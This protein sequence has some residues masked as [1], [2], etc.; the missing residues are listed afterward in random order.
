MNRWLTMIVCLVVSACGGGPGSVDTTPLGM[1]PATTD[2]GSAEAEATMTAEASAPEA[3]T[4]DPTEAAA[5]ETGAPGEDAGAG[6][7]SQLSPPTFDPP[8]GVIAAGSTIRIAC[9]MLPPTGVIL[10]TLDGN[11]PNTSTHQYAGPIQIDTDTIARATCSDP[12]DGFANS[13]VATAIY[14][15]HPAPAPD[16]GAPTDA[17]ATIDAAP[18]LVWQQYQ[19]WYYIAQNPSPTYYNPQNDT[20]LYGDWEP[21]TVAATAPGMSGC[22]TTSRLNTSLP[23]GSNTPVCPTVNTADQACCILASQPHPGETAIPGEWAL[24]CFC[25]VHSAGGPAGVWT[26]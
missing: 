24:T 4:A 21:S 23:V 20:W 26:F 16:A 11:D 7:L 5:P 15:I 17:G 8:S 9:P 3:G 10:F 19:S 25:N 22:I 2:A 6:S 12:T 18:A 13:Q 1:T 14:G